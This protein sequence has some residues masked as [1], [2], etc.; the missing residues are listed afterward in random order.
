MVVLVV[1]VVF[2]VIYSMGIGYISF[3]QEYEKKFVRPAMFREVYSRIQVTTV[4][5]LL[6]SGI[7]GCS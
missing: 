2:T 3:V 6:C 7:Y 4:Y 5:Q 1:V